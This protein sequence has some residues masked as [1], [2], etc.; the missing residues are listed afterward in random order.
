MSQRVHHALLNLAWSVSFIHSSAQ[1]FLA[2]KLPF[3]GPN[4]IDQVFCDVEPLLKLACMDT[5]VINLLIV[6]NSG[7]YAQ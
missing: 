6:S 7:P 1:L 2:L 3:C 4:V 5:Y